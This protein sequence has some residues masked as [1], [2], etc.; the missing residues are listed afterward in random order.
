MK[1]NEM[2]IKEACLQSLS[3]LKRVAHSKEIYQH[4]VSRGYYDFKNARTPASTV[5]ALLGDFVRNGDDRVKRISGK[6]G[7][8][9]Y[10]LTKDEHL[11][12]LDAINQNTPSTTKASKS[13][14]ERDLHM[15]LSSFLK[16]RGVYSKTILHERSKNSADSHQKWIHPD[17]VGMKPLTLKHQ[18]SQAFLKMVNQAD[19]FKLY[20]YEI[21]KEI[22]TDY[23]LKKFF[24]QAVSNSSWANFGYLV[25]FH[26]SDSL[27]E[28]L[29]RL[30]QSFGIGII[31]L[32]AN[33][34]KSKILFQPQYRELDFKTIDKICKINLEFEQFI[35]KTHKLI[36]A[37]DGY[38]EPSEKAL[39]EFCDGYFKNDSEFEEYCREKNIPLEK[40]SN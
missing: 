20:S 25:A 14:H 5:S 15:L 22:N 35:F 9:T 30:N 21:K 4:M 16:N 13:Y 28:E 32:N 3:D 27:T 8:F 38:E 33:P 26:I 37:A 1:K 6:G 31:Q 39:E 24:F 40:E 19:V 17:M 7:T 11:I 29:E 2:T 12:D 36:Q 34:Y 23:D 18:T 10:Y